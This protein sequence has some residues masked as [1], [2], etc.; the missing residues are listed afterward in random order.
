M[1]KSLR[2]K[3]II[4]LLFLLIIIIIKNKRE[5][6]ENIQNIDYIFDNN[7][8]IKYINL[9]SSKER[10]TRMIRQLKNKNFKFSRF[11]AYD[12]RKIDQNFNNNLIHDFNTIDFNGSIYNFK[13]GS[14]GNFI[15]QLTSLFV[16]G[17]VAIVVQ[18]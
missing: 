5:N 9:E 4:F 2:I 17:K 10:N 3:S 1:R 6:Y 7:F 12:G 15:S 18:K 16:D 14:L 11:D 13:K 8:D